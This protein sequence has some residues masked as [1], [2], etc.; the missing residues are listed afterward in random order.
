MVYEFK[1]PDVGEG[2]TEGKLVKWNVK[3]GDTIKVD[4]SVAEVETDKSIVEIPSPVAGIVE[5][6]FFS[7]G[8]M[9]EVGKI[10]MNINEDGTVPEKPSQEE[11]KE[12]ETQEN[13]QTDNI[14]ND[15]KVQEDA[16]SPEPKQP[17][18]PEK[19]K[20]DEVSRQESK[21]IEPKP[22]QNENQDSEEILAM[23]G[24][25]A[26]AKQKGIDLSTVKPTGKHGQITLEDL[27]PGKAVQP[28]PEQPS[29]PEKPKQDEETPTKEPEQQTHEQDYSKVEKQSTV[30]QS[31]VIASPSVR[32]LAREKGVDINQ[33]KG[34]GDNGR[35]FASDLENF[36]KG[37]KEPAKPEE[38]SKV[39]EDAPSSEPKQPSQPE[40]PKQDEETLTKE[41]EQQVSKTEGDPGDRRVPITGIRSVISKRMMDSLQNTAQVTHT[42]QANISKLVQLRRIQKEM[43]EK[44]GVKLTYL[45]FFLKAFVATAEEFP[46]FNAVIDDDNNEIVYKKHFDIGIAVDTAKGL[47]VPVVKSVEDK[48]IVDIAKELVDTSIKAREGKLSPSEMNGSSFTVSSVGSL[49]GE[50]FTPIINYPNT[51]I[52]G[53]GKIVKKPIVDYDGEIIV[54]DTVTFSLTFDHRVID[55]AQAARFLTRYIELLE[56]PDKLFLEMN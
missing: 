37:E 48:S 6:L 19:S 38:N 43:L 8:D 40:K 45:P 16:P 9:L 7:E 31:E 21:N 51:A 18:Q 36:E 10:I 24:V 54:A 13:S 2:I 52:L 42:D 46:I 30:L 53:V 41:P 14:Q 12:E 33:V 4:D 11:S 20:Q 39:Q 26:V 1:F 49:G 22:V 50:V 3:K 32:Q 47:L 29:Q 5:D 55:G 56:N 23:P 25:R 44:E 28:Q 17:S 27:G 15:S 35:V 34:S